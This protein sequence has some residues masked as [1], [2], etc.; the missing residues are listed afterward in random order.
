MSPILTVAALD[1]VMFPLLS[2]TMNILP[3][4]K[5]GIAIYLRLFLQRQNSTLVGLQKHP[6]RSTCLMKSV[7]LPH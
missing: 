4:Y 2:L 6:P 3:E 7:C 5:Q 1:I